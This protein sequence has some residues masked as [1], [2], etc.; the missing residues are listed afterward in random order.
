MKTRDTIIL[1]AVVLLVGLF[2]FIYERNL[3]STGEAKEREGRILPRLEPA[4]VSRIAIRS[5]D[6]TAILERLGETEEWRMTSPVQAEA[7]G[8]VV[9]GLLSDIEFMTFERKVEKATGEQRKGFGLVDPS[10]TAEISQGSDVMKFVLGVDAEAGGVYLALDGHDTVY[11]V[12]P[13]SLE[14]LRK[15]PWEFRQK[16]LLGKKGGR[17]TRMQVSIGR[18]PPV[19]LEERDGQWV[20]TVGD[21]AAERASRRAT[22]KVVAAL[23]GLKAL[24]YVQDGL[25]EKDAKM[26]PAAPRVTFEREDGTRGTLVFDEGCVEEEDGE[27]T[28]S[29]LFVEPGILACVGRAAR[30]AILTPVDELRLTAPAE[31]DAFEVFSLEA[32][33]A[34][35][36]LVRLEKDDEGEWSITA[37]GA[38]RAAEGQAVEDLV[39]ALNEKKAPS[40]LP[41]P[42]DLT[43][44]GLDPGSAVE[45]VIL[46]VVGDEVGTVLLGRD[47]GGAV[48]FMRKAEDRYGV[49]GNVP[50]LG[51]AGD[52]W[53]YLNRTVLRR[54][55]FDAARLELEGPISHVL[56][57][58]EGS[59]EFE[60]P[61]APSPDSADVRDTVETFSSL[62]AL[63]FLS[64]AKAASLDG[65][66]LARPEWVVTVYYDGEEA[67]KAP[68]PAD[69]GADPE[70][71]GEPVRLLIGES[72]E[73]GRAALLEGQGVNAVMLISEQVFFRLT[74]PLADKGVFARAAQDVER[75]ELGMK[76]LSE[77]FSVKN[78][79]VEAHVAGKLGLFP[80]EDLRTFFEKLRTLRASRVVSYGP[81]PAEAS[82]EAP[83]LTITLLAKGGGSTSVAFGSAFDAQ[84]EELVYAT[85]S[86][87]G[88]VYGV[89]SS[90]VGFAR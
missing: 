43:P 32:R 41:L 21:G 60:I 77:T 81:A 40:L 87:T 9:D 63:R 25:A 4:E 31:V 24:R 23:E 11:V 6:A 68:A 12:D 58:E 10:L 47:A 5:G 27:P 86:T 78:G 76:G 62:S 35:E 46:D 89:P 80:L 17:I 88:A 85:C 28:V 16:R 14:T 29:A 55:Y 66:G 33:R 15:E 75:I 39:Q 8:A 54:D 69:A 48:T 64:D 26:A 53:S 83:V 45:I 61:V 82:M 65:F 52:P 51:G 7:E 73:E 44:L 59:W 67:E 90:L 3:P 38:S 13:M 1:L 56:V 42:A 49:L 84:A 18:E 36:V 57:K 19:V 50:E 20:V 79:H 2:I 22:D 72:F 70:P 37:P 34:G 74:R 30:D 71:A